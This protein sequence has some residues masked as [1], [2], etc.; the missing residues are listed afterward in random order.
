LWHYIK[1]FL[2]GLLL[3]WLLLFVSFAVS[4][5][6]VKAAIYS[7]TLAKAGIGYFQKLTSG[8]GIW[9]SLFVI[10]SAWIWSFGKKRQ[11]QPVVLGSNPNNVHH[12]NQQQT[13]TEPHDENKL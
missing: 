12:V 13:Q 7:V 10:L 6:F 5:G 9:I 4:D 2:I 3:L 11:P 1:G 8:T